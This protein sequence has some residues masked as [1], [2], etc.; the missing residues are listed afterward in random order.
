MQIQAADDRS[1]L[2]Q[3]ARDTAQQLTASALSPWQ[4]GPTQGAFIAPGSKPGGG[5]APVDGVRISGHAADE[6]RQ[7]VNSPDPGGQRVD[8]LKGTFASLGSGLPSPALQN[9]AAARHVPPVGKTQHDQAT[10][11]AGSHAIQGGLGL[12]R[13]GFQGPESLGPSLAGG[14]GASS[15]AFVPATRPGSGLNPTQTVSPSGGASTS[16]TGFD[17]RPFTRR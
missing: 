11:A 10:G 6:L 8:A 2:K 14:L 1:I 13:G 7:R 3:R 12:L 17:N 5:A 9:G 4:T 16:A 15:H